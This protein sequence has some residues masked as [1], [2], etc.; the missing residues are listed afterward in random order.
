MGQLD[1]AS[2]R[3]LAL[4]L[5][6]QVEGKH[7][8]KVSRRTASVA[9]LS[10]AVVP[11]VRAQ[12]W[13]TKPIRIVV[14]TGAGGIT[15]ILARRIVAS[16]AERLGQPVVIDNRPGAGGIIGTEIV[17]K[18]PPDGYTL[19]MVLSQPPDQPGALPEAALRH[20]QRFRA[21]HDAH[22][23][24]ARA[25]RARRRCRRRRCRS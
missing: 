2:M 22:Q 3:F 17:A 14:P 21:G 23:V 8:M 5:L 16:A 20:D 18:A 10:L 1:R 11:S 6:T 4:L 25:G 7:H 15:D 9:L 12:A 19:L 13:P 24:A